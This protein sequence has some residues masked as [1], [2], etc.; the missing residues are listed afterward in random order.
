MIGLPI[1]VAALALRPPV[2]LFEDAR[3]INC[4]YNSIAAADLLVA[5][6][7]ERERRPPRGDDSAALARVSAIMQACADEYAWTP[8]R[9]SAALN[10]AIGLV[11]RDKAVEVLRG[12]GLDVHFLDEVQAELGQS[13]IA[14]LLSSA[15]DSNLDHAAD[16]AMRRLVARGHDIPPG[17]EEWVRLGHEIARGLFGL[18][19]ANRSAGDFTLQ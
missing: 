8:N 1:V 13:G 17:S 5:E 11:M 18:A 19:L 4:P 16:V 3:G 7:V 12:R 2:I 9:A 10:N 14:A 15:R 6:A